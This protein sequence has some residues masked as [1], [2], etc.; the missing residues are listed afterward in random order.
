L[1]LRNF[2]YKI[3]YDKVKPVKATNDL[4]NREKALLSGV[5]GAAAAYATSP[6]ELIMTRFTFC[7]QKF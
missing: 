3:V 5:V 1:F 4:T 2:L 6:F 7:L